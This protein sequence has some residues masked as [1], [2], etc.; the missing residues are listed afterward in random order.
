MNPKIN[1]KL[2]TD[3]P[4][5]QKIILKHDVELVQS[6]PGA[7]TPELLRYYTLTGNRDKEIV[8]QVFLATNMFENKITEFEI[9][10]TTECTNPVLVNDP[11]FQDQY[12]WALRL[13]QAPCAWS[14]TQGN[15]NIY[16]YCCSVC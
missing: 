15:P 2:A 16:L 6:Y 5:I 11:H 3:D 13:I 14:I 8:I 10:Y 1:I 4:E 7:K 12:G 9:A